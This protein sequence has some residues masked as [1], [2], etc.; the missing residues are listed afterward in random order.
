MGG[1]SNLT[2]VEAYCWDKHEYANVLSHVCL[3]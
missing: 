2:Y 3:F 1:I